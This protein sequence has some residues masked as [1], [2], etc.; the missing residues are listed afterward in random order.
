MIN[1]NTYIIHTYAL[2]GRAVEWNIDEGCHD[3]LK[4]E[5]IDEGCHDWLKEE[6]I[7]EG[8]HDWVKEEN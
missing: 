1:L 6:N 2:E 5:N 4:K 8:C 7:D 3:W